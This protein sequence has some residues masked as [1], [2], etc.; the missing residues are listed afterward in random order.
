VKAQVLSGIRRDSTNPREIA[1][2]TWWA[3]AFPGHAYGRPVSGTLESVP[4]ITADDLRAYTRRIFARDGLKIAF[5]GDLDPPMVARIVDE[6]FG[7]LPEHAPLSAVEGATPQALG[8]IVRV[9]LDVPQTVIQFG[10]AGL[11]RKDP[12]FIAGV[13]V[14]HVLSGGSLTSRLYSEVREKRGLVYSIFTGIQP[15]AYAGVFSGETATRADRAAETIALVER[16]IARLAAE[17]PTAEE[18]AKAKSYLKGAFA[19]NLDTSSKIAAQLV[20]LQIDDLGTEYLEQRKQLIEAVTLSDAKRVAKRVL[21]GP[22][23]VAIVGRPPE[24]AGKGPEVVRGRVGASPAV[25]PDSAGPA[26]R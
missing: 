25:A 7:S 12:D 13:L 15:F 16:E 9:D 23:L 17:G 11:L 18:L 3:A 8:K 14:N 19:L 20:Q 10:G 1:G 6:I 2:L 5:V 4:R 26:L 21:A 24:M 22:L